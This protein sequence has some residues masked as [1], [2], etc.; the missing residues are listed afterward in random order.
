[1]CSVLCVI[2]LR[3]LLESATQRQTDAPFRS[4][5][6]NCTGIRINITPE[7]R[8][9]LAQSCF[10]WDFSEGEVRLSQVALVRQHLLV[11]ILFYFHWKWEMLVWRM[12]WGGSWSLT[13]FPSIPCRGWD[14]M[15][16][17]SLCRSPSASLSVCLSGVTFDSFS[18][19][20]L[21][22]FL[23]LNSKLIPLFG[24]CKLK[25]NLSVFHVVF[26]HR[27]P[28]SS[29]LSF[30]LFLSFVSLSFSLP[31]CWAGKPL[32]WS[33]YLFMQVIHQHRV[34]FKA[35]SRKPDQ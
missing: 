2:L 6:S 8:N 10:Y 26:H 29:S 18:L 5:S 28:F 21:L 25:S 34:A 20:L 32:M 3:V 4:P 17:I 27:C 33:R 30:L 7:I 22:H 19:C 12:G 11:N 35:M 1:M 14:Q 16:H 9:P 23:L 31:P 13:N 15:K 24:K